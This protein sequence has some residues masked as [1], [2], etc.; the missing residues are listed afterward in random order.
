ML[1]EFGF[2]M[3]DSSRRHVTGKLGS[4]LTDG[5]YY[6]GRNIKEAARNGIDL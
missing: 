4:G 2:G 6:P 5:G 3:L 1:G